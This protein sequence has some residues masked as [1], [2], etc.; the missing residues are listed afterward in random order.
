MLARAGATA[1]ALLLISRLL[2]VI[3]ESV[4]AAAFGASGFGDI[5]VLMLALPDWLTGISIA[6]GLA[7]VLLPHWAALEQQPHS[8]TNVA[9]LQRQIAKTLLGGGA[10]AGLAIGIAAPVLPEWLAPGLPL[11]LTSDAIAGLRWSAI[12]L[13]L[14]LI[15]ALWSTRLQ[16]EHDFAGL[17]S[18]NLVVN[19]MLITGMIAMGSLYGALSTPHEMGVVLFCAMAGRL[20]WQGV[21]LSKLKPQILVASE[22]PMPALKLPPVAS[23]VWAALASGLPLALPFAAR[24]LA[25]SSGEGSLVTFNYAWKL[26]E[27]PLVLAVQ[28]VASLSFPSLTRAF[29]ARSE[30]FSSVRKSFALSWAMGCATASALVVASPALSQILFGWGR[31][32]PDALARISDWSAIGAWGLL[33]QALTAVGLTVLATLRKMRSAV[34]A[35]A[36]ALMFLVAS[37]SQWQ[38]GA[39]L[40]WIMNIS[41]LFVATSVLSTI[42]RALNERTDQGPWLPWREML[43]PLAV[44]CL[45]GTF[46]VP[47]DSRVVGISAAVLAGAITIAAA[48]L[49][50]PTLREAVRQ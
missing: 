14:A 34:F 4:Q 25:S 37:G 40:M 7:Y 30:V 48:W 5:V 46:T 23:W 6:G 49:S 27:L 18:A 36:I 38:S 3:R 20:A 22:A 17:Y 12:A 9:R 24:S 21:R 45:A 11:N 8:V 13:P 26:V 31:M 10:L 1:L 19:T 16:H 33:P 44:T 32:T 29:A 28:V 47:T 43:C 2:G 42:R 41:S 15:A 39:Q 35:Y 50:G